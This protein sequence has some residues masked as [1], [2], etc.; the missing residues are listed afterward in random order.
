MVDL[1]PV[2]REDVLGPLGVKIFVV[3][4]D[5]NTEVKFYGTFRVLLVEALVF[6]D[7]ST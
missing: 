6:G 2:G 4:T 3:A 5:A 1:L 7:D